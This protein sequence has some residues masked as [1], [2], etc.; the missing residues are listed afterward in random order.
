MFLS[1]SGY[2]CGI[3]WEGSTDII[4]EYL[5]KAL[6]Q[7]VGVANGQQVAANTS[8]KTKNEDDLMISREMKVNA[9]VL[10]QW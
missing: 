9:F 10:L 5:W 4:I 8:I 3:P 1:C 7:I 6:V 2:W